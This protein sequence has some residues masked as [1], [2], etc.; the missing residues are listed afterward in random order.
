MKT[1]G[2][3]ALLLF[4]FISASAQTQLS[5]ETP[6]WAKDLIIYE[7]PVKSFTS[8]E[9]PETGTF[10]STMEKIPYLADLGI[11]GIWITGH[12]WADKGHFYGIWT[13]YAVIRPDSIDPSLGTRGDLKELADLCHRYNIKVFLDIVTHGVM[14]FSPL[15]SEHPAWFRSGSWGMTDYDW[16]GDHADLDEWWIRTHTDYVRK[17]G[18]D[19]YRLDVAIYRTDLW[20]K[21]KKECSDSGHPIVIW[22]ELDSY[23]D[24]VCDFE[25]RQTTL[26][27]QEKGLDRYNP[28]NYNAAEHFT[29]FSKKPS[30]YFVKIY[31]SDGSIATGNS[32]ND[33]PYTKRIIEQMYFEKDIDIRSD[34]RINVLN[35]FI[36]SGKT[37]GISDKEKLII[38]VSNLKADIDI[39]KISVTGPNTNEEIWRLENQTP[40]RI[41]FRPGDSLVLEAAVRNPDIKLFSIQISSHDDGWDSFP[42]DSDP[43]VAEGSRCTFGYSCLFLP[44]VPVFM[45]GEEFNAD[46]VPL[47]RLTPDLY[48]KGVP[49]KGRWLYGSW[50]HWDQLKDSYHSQMLADV[51]RMIAVRKRFPDL[52]S[53]EN[54]SKP[55]N[56]RPLKY[57]SDCSLPVPYIIWNEKKAIII[58]GN[59]TDRDVTLQISVPDEFQGHKFESLTDIWNNKKLRIINGQIKINIKK[60]K[61]SGG[62]LAVLIFSGSEN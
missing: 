23:S 34:L 16:Y 61:S 4:S 55:V 33:E 3:I 50:I 47:P 39:Y 19:G 28:L 41:G 7:I 53:A 29:N 6:A 40:Y 8:P 11:T 18:I 12:N 27:I 20:K 22:S 42:E 43:Y 58:A 5:T 14:N 26:S 30:F 35:D 24:G 37:G 59:N 25:Q 38:S 17:C 36:P 10:R 56:I 2:V 21:I 44:A 60:D 49:G 45:S 48:G 9:G 57:V 52:F 51:K 1:S 54:N 31:Y 62:G 15:V 32:W 46:Y 13:Q